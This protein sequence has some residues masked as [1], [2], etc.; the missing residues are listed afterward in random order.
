MDRVV[1]WV[2]S[3]ALLVLFVPAALYF[4]LHVS[5]ASERALAE[6]GSGVA[7]NLASQIVS[8]LL[9]GD[10]LTLHDTLSK[11]LSADSKIRYVCVE[12]ERGEITA[13]TFEGGY[14]P[15]L[16]A[17]WRE[18]PSGAVR[19]RT[20]EGPF[21]DV[22][23]PIIDGRLGR[24]H[25]GLS[26]G[27]AVAATRGYLFIWG[28]SF[29][30]A[31][32]VVLWGAHLVAARISR[33]LRRLEDKVQRYPQQPW[34]DGE[35]NISGTKEVAAL[36]R[37]FSEMAERQETLERERAVTQA[38]LIHAQRLAALGE[39]AAG[40]S[41]EVHNP[42]DGM[43][44]CVR[45][46]EAD[47]NKSERQAKYAPMLRDGLERI[48]TAM[49]Q[50]LTFAKTGRDT[51]VEK[52]APGDVVAS[53]V[54]VLESRLAARNVKL[55]WRNVNGACTCLCNESSL[56]QALLNLVLNAAEAA[57]ENAAPEVSIEIGHDK[58][59]VRIAVED[60]GP[61]I[62]GDLRE[63]IFEP[64]FTTKPGEKGTG[65]GLSISRQLVRAVGGELELAEGPTRLGGARFVIRIPC[66]ES[67]T[68]DE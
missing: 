34:T 13:S 2:G 36:A 31:F 39:L 67:R 27:E 23:A 49:Q 57:Q 43:L 25:V 48:A 44:E 14:P 56:S 17:L 9:T 51:S 16:P 5:S 24:L 29:V 47:K 58:T 42:L 59:W 46:L 55:S 1:A 15:G 63:R 41:H 20:D 65:L 50:M 62:P 54:P 8:P 53:L 32:A 22:A 26:R 10:R 35:E 64:F 37:G 18:N 30:G 68:C 12:N 6:H 38:R 33:P 45:Y 3:L 52:C 40:L 19:F 28:A 61:D 11:T 4:T 21:T 60:N 66:Q 7:E